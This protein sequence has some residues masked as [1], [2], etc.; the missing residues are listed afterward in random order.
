MT[1][2]V[3]SK[4]TMTQRERLLAVLRGETPDRIPFIDRMEI[5]YNAKQRTGTMPP[6][7]L[8]LS[9]S[10]VHEKV[11]M[12]E[13]K[14]EDPYALR[15]RGVEM[16]CFFN[17]EHLLSEQDPIFSGFP[18]AWAPPFVPLDKAGITRIE[19]RT[20]VG[21]ASVSWCLTESMIPTAVDPYLEEHFVKEDN[22]LRVAEFILDRAEFVAWFDRFY[23]EDAKLGCNG[24]LAPVTQRAPFQQLLLEYFGEVP[25]FYALSDIPA[26]VE[27]LLGQVDEHFVDT[28]VKLSEFDYPYVEFP[29]NLDGTMTNPKLF[30]EYCLPAYQRYTD[31]LHG[32]GKCVGSHTDGD[33]KRLLGPL[34]ESGLDVCESVSPF[35]LTTTTFDELWGSWGAAGPIMWGPIPSPLLEGNR[36]G[37]VLYDYLDHLLETV[38]NG[39]IILGISDMVVGENLVER[40]EYVAQKIE[41]FDPMRF[42][43]GGGSAKSPELRSSEF[44]PVEAGERV[45]T[46]RV[47]AQ[48]AKRA[49]KEHWD[50]I[51]DGLYDRTIDG[52]DS[53]IA[54]YVEEGLALGM[55]PKDILFDSLIPAL[56]EVGH[57]FEEGSYFVPEM[58]LS[59]RAMNA[60][61]EVL[62]PLIA[63]SGGLDLGRIVIGT[64]RGDVHNIGKNLCCTMLEGAGFDVIDLGVNTEPEAFVA[65]VEEHAPQIVGI[66]AL[67]TT[68]APMIGTTIEAVQVAG[69]RDKV[70]ILVGGAAVSS[71]TCAYYGA[72]AYAG[73]AVTAV[74]KT[75]EMLGI[76][77]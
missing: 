25:L 23:V 77:S 21:A 12:G 30:E 1:P 46:T 43:T 64:V 19:F 70:Q 35:P 65:A 41:Q 56:T 17:D 50:E 63:E 51:L 5:W 58:L 3:N 13:L 32:Q 72:D 36:E 26:K 57:L 29:D 9:L 49:S 54:N 22:D 4:I 28:L 20:P 66:S 62:R 37:S 48:Q 24:F 67:L 73:D 75:K 44:A 18:A 33:I 6:S 59:A 55:E 74:T 16:A 42:N 8:G 71:A 68:A 47:V 39:R 15:L 52:L 40:L 69:L 7:F 10:E 34:K 38:G 11:G 31:I 45:I 61:M 14:F 76:N 27:R 2:M 53:E 60:G